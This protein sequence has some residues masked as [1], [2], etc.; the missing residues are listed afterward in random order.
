MTITETFGK[1]ISEYTDR[2]AIADG[3][4]IEV[5]PAKWPALLITA[6]IKHAC[7]REAAKGRRD[8]RQC[9][10]PL[11]QDCIMEVQRKMKRDRTADWAKLTGT[12]A[13]V[14]FVT[15]NSLGGMTIMMPE[16][17]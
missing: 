13:G 6:S 12:V 15:P 2:D 9:L 14:V 8:Y 3:M 17:V 4:L 10:I 16:D 5:D 1:V 7:E 11:V